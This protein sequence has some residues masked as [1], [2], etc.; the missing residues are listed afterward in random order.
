MQSLTPVD[1]SHEQPLELEDHGGRL[2]GIPRWTMQTIGPSGTPL[3]MPYELTASRADWDAIMA[4]YFQRLILSLFMRGIVTRLHGDRY[5]F[6]LIPVEYLETW[7]KCEIPTLMNVREVIA[8]TM[9]TIMSSGPV[10]ADAN[11]T[12]YRFVHWD[13]SPPAAPP[14]DHVCDDCPLCYDPVHPREVFQWCERCKTP[15]HV[16]CMAKCLL[17]STQCPTCNLPAVMLNEKL[18]AAIEHDRQREDFERFL[19]SHGVIIR[20]EEHEHEQDDEEVQ[21]HPDMEHI[22]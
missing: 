22:D 19:T 8:L 5:L 16:K 17:R 10:H 7:V 18:A 9:K 13:V 21:G 3:H 15:I 12:F 20:D 4:V 2:R 1:V 11:K 14:A 6:S